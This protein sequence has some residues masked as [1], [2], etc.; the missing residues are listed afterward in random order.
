MHDVTVECANEGC[1]EC[2]MELMRRQ[3]EVLECKKDK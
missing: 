1:E 3:E 2:Q